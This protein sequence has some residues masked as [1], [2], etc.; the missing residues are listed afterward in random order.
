MWW[1]LS[2]PVRWLVVVG[3]ALTGLAELLNLAASFS[4]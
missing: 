4:G 2:W 3:L 1:R